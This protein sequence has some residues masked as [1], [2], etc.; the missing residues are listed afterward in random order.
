MAVGGSERRG[1]SWARKSL[2]GLTVTLFT[3]SVTSCS[4]VPNP[5][6][7]PPAQL[8]FTRVKGAPGCYKSAV[9]PEPRSAVDSLR[10]YYELHGFDDIPSAGPGWIRQNERCRFVRHQ[11]VPPQRPNAYGW[12]GTFDPGFADLSGISAWVV[13]ANAHPARIYLAILECSGCNLP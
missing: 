3:T 10:S 1:A 8:G 5:V 2:L 4:S 12:V 9:L 13:P 6:P 11:L 7:R